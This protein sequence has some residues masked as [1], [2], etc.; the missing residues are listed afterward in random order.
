[1][2][3]ILWLLACAAAAPLAAPGQDAD[4]PSDRRLRELL[5]RLGSDDPASRE[6]ASQEL[7][8][9]GQKWVDAIRQLARAGDDPEIRARAHG[10]LDALRQDPTISRDK[11]R[12]VPVD[13]TLEEGTLSDLLSA[14]TQKT[15]I[16]FL[17]HFNE[18]ERI[19]ELAGVDLRGVSLEAALDSICSDYDLAWGIDAEQR[20]FL[21]PRA[22]FF[23]RYGETRLVDVSALVDPPRDHSPDG[24]NAGGMSSEELIDLLQLSID[25][26]SWGYDNV[27]MNID[28]GRL[29]VRHLPEV[30]RRVERML[31]ELRARLA[32]PVKVELLGILCDPAK[33]RSWIRPDLRDPTPEQMQALLAKV[34]AEEEVKRFAW[35]QMNAVNGRGV[36]GVHSQEST[37]VVGFR[38][39]KAGER[40]FLLPVTSAVSEGIEAFV[41]PRVSE[42]GRRAVVEME[43]KATRILEIET[44]KTE[45][46]E[47]RLPKVAS[48]DFKQT[49]DLAH[50]RW[51][52]VGM[53]TPSGKPDLRLIL[54]ARVEIGK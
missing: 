31:G 18:A 14:V 38:V 33:L 43:I 52:I 32:R 45:A 4:E 22:A 49:A 13:A 53:A 42:D 51:G 20:V 24:S 47:I 41:R 36:R 26:A 50:D 54:L 44:V 16:K 6:R 8:R 3:T 5:E 35:L 27:W 12:N 40:S 28:G 1:M 7:T 30:I 48:L 17:L 25:P 21:M 11:L 10:V 23:D 46:G 9:L 29:R 15:G 34:H 37:F 39:D 19:G 2:R